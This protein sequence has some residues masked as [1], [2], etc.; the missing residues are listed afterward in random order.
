MDCQCLLDD[1]FEDSPTLVETKTNWQ[2]AALRLGEELASVGPDGYYDFTPE[3]WL[4]WA[5]ESARTGSTDTLV[6]KYITQ[7]ENDLEHNQ[8]VLNRKAQDSVMLEDEIAKYREAL[9]MAI[10]WFDN[11]EMDMS[12]HALKSSKEIVNACK[13]A[14]ETEL[15]GN[16]EQLC[17]KPVAWKYKTNKVHTWITEDMPPEDAYDENTLT[18]LYT[19]PTK[20]LS[21]DKIFNLCPYAEESYEET[22]YCGFRV[23]EKAH[24]IGVKDE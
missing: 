4:E 13:A 3:Q 2:N 6:D 1:V 23:A 24:G 15:S 22:F 9:R 19:K 17:Q 10:E 7:L 16:S 5:L 20:P 18:P 21:D 14:L 11:W 12:S 8:K